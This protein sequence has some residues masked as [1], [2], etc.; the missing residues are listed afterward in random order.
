VFRSWLRRLRA[1]Q[2]L[3]TKEDRDAPGV[4]AAA[5]P[6]PTKEDRHEPGRAHLVFEDGS[7]VEA[8]LDPEAQA[9]VEYLARRAVAPPPPEKR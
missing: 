8:D 6:P 4:S 3:P 1:A 7:I 9:K 2:P 5:Q